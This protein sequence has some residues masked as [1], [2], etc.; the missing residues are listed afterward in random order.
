M[1]KTVRISLAN[2]CQLLFGAAVVLILSAA[3]TVAWQRMQNLVNVGLEET[4]HKLADA[5]LSRMIRIDPSRRALEK[6]FSQDWSEQGINLTVI[7]KDDFESASRADPFLAEAIARFD[8]HGDRNKH[9][10]PAVDKQNQR[11]HRFA[12]AIRKSDRQR[13]EADE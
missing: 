10:S 9:H 11:Y 7:M 5:Y 1:T 13:L 12:R 2:K 8:T 4:A 3:L 6:S